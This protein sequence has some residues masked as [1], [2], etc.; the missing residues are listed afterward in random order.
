LA[1][2]LGDKPEY[3]FTNEKG[4]ILDKDNWRRR[5]FAKAFEKAELRKIRIHDMRHTYATLRISKGDNIADVSNQLGHHS[6]KLTMDTYYHWVP[7]KKKDEVD[8]LDDSSFRHLSAPPLHPEAT[9][10]LT[11]IG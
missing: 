11:A 6:V 2:G 5:V 8:G 4:L 1:L 7:G 3:L 10:D 9:N